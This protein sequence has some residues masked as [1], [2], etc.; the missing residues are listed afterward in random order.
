MLRRTL[1]LYIGRAR[2]D[3]TSV[4]TAA[5]HEG[6]RRRLPA[7][8]PTACTGPWLAAA[9]GSR[10][11]LIVCIGARQTSDGP[12]Y[13]DLLAVHVVVLVERRRMKEGMLGRLL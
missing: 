13:A 12:G 3:V 6:A 5:H 10:I 1:V 9:L 11:A 8:V 7:C 4:R 2:R